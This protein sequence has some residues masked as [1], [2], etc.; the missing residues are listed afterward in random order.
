M[1]SIFTR[2]LFLAL[3]LV[4]AIVF[5]HH[6]VTNLYDSNRTIEVEGIVTE[7]IWRNPHIQISIQVTD[8]D[9]KQELWNNASEAMSNLRRWKIEAGFIKAG[10]KV[11]L[12]GRP[13]HQG[14]GMYISHVL[15]PSGVEVILDR[16]NFE[17]RWSETT[18]T[19]AE[20]IKE[21]IGD[22]NSPELG[23]FRVWSH[24]DSLGLLFPEDGVA[25]FDLSQ[26]PLTESTKAAIAAFDK[27]RDNPIGSCQA[28]G[29]PT[30]MEAPYPHQFVQDGENILWHQEEQDTIRTIHMAPD[31][32]AEGKPTNKLGYSIG[33]WEDEYT[34]VVTTVNATWGRYNTMGIPLTE[35][36]VM[37]ERFMLAEDG[38]R[39]DYAISVTDPE[40]FT[41][42][43]TATTYWLFYPDAE[44]GR[45]ECLLDAENG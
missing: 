24:P 1:L 9:G 17:P 25:D 21:E 27:T 31:A 14:N 8:Q 6:N 5:A 35:E 39:L 41:A 7:A 38:S 12:A 22:P 15:T 44:V 4:P 28:K 42:P 26:Y 32:T 36:A 43:H 34:L 18:V 45:Y 16:R 33:H 19:I 30:I 13:A 40:T 3:T 20:Y 10:D 29:M 2:G 37:V 23:I 11:R